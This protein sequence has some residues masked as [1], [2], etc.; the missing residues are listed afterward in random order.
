MIG[1][2][3]GL[4]HPGSLNDRM[5]LGLKGTIAQAE[6]HMIR[7]RMD[8]GIRNKAKRGCVLRII[9]ALS[10]SSPPEPLADKPGR[11]PN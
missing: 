6:L 8:G 7:Q 9:P 4:Y 2:L 11:S 1:D 10:R 5:L 3:D